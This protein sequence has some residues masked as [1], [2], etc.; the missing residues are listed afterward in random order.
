MSESVPPPVAAQPPLSA[1]DDKL[2]ASLAHF[3]NI[4]SFLAPLI[5]W[6]VLKDRGSK[7]ATEGK[8]ATNWGINVIG[9]I[10]ALS[11][12]SAILGFIPIIG[13]VIG[14][15]VGLVIWALVIVNII[16]A[17]IGG[18][19]VQGGGSYRY[20]VNIRWIK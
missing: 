20:P 15:L 19:R 1:A 10:I 7:V 6:L 9:A 5:I 18:V 4:V 13:F 2:W 8:E 17:I 3:G 11:I 16:F 14:L 12:V